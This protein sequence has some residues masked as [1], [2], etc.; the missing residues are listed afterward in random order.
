MGIICSRGKQPMQ[1]DKDKAGAERSQKRG[2]AVD[3]SRQ[4]GSK[5]HDQDGIKRCFAC[6]GA[7]MAK[8]QHGQSS[9]QD[10]DSANGDLQKRKVL[11]LY[12]NPQHRRQIVP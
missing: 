2:A 7:F 1:Q 6:K 8:P 3:R 9:K 12:P 4:D 5:N 10:D 11:W